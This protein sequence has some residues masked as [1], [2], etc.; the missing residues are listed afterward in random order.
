MKALFKTDSTCKSGR[1]GNIESPLRHKEKGVD[2]GCR[3]ASCPK[4][5]SHERIPHYPLNILRHQLSATALGSRASLTMK[6]SNDWKCDRPELGFIAARTLCCFSFVFY[7]ELYILNPKSQTLNPQTYVYI[8]VYLSFYA[9]KRALPRCLQ[10]RTVCW[11]QLLPPPS[12]RGC[13]GHG[14]LL[15][16]AMG[17]GSEIRG[18]WRLLLSPL[19]GVYKNMQG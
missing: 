1:P 16:G 11:T 14:P 13:A 5:P 8:Y 6:V 2:G 15:S 12:W 10:P 9:L 17:F 19:K 4:L 7:H 18:Y 3:E